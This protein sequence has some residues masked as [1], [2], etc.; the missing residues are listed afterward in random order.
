MI[1]ISLSA[2]ALAIWVYLVFARG[3]FWLCRERDDTREPLP[4]V[5]PQIA[6]VVPARN[7]FGV[8]QTESFELREAPQRLQPGIAETAVVHVQ[9]FEP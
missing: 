6:V 4:A 2:V 5:L 7:E 9:R 3:G 1:A 8:P